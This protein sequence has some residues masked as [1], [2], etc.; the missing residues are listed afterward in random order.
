MST[1]TYLSLAALGVT[2]LGAGALAYDVVVGYV[3]R[4]EATMYQ[5]QVRNFREWRTR[6]E[7]GVLLLPTPPYSPEEK[8]D[9][10]DELRTK[11]KRLEDEARE[12]E[13][14]ILRSHGERAFGWALM[15]LVLIFLG[16]AL[17]L[18]VL[19]VSSSP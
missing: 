11:Y 12:S 8:H 15:G 2:F 9:L 3:R 19:L 1:E 16:V 17:Q 14:R 13:E 10:L 4:N 5:V 7:Q 6:F 18:R